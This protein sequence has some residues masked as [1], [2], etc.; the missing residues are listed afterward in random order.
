MPDVT[1]IGFAIIVVSAGVVRLV[2]LVRGALRD[3]RNAR[4]VHG[5]ARVPIASAGEGQATC[6]VGHIVGEL[7]L[8][9]P[10]TGRR[11]VY[12]AVELEEYVG[13]AF[14]TWKN[15]GREDSARG[16][17]TIADASGRALIDSAGAE[18]VIDRDAGVRVRPIGDHDPAARAWLKSRG[19]AEKALFLKRKYRFVESAL[20]AD[21]PVAVVGLGVH[22]P[23]PDAASVVRGYRDGPPTRL[24]LASTAAHRLFITDAPTATGGRP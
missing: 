9:A 8:V 5:A 16:T 15:C 23:D 20:T 6:V 10:F 18:I 17:F 3:G 13:N 2:A 1:Y 11:C 7:P 4:L 24:H 14:E 21:D 19:L 12:W 22:E